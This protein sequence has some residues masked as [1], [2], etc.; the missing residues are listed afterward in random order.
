MNN[1]Q[2]REI[3]N[4]IASELKIN[5]I[6]VKNVIQRF[7]DFIRLVLLQGDKVELREFG[8]FFPKLRK[9]RPGRNPN[10]PDKTLIIK[11]HYI[12]FFKAGRPFKI[13]MRKKLK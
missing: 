1:Y 12:P 9:E 7:I 8:T 2:K 6:D 11:Q 13:E 3:V 10:K 4:S 5:Q